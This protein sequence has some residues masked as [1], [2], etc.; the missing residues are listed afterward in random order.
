M[1]LIIV[2][3]ELKDLKKNGEGYPDPTACEAIVDAEGAGADDAERYHKLIG[4][5]LRIIEIAGFKPEE[6]IVLK[7]LRTGKIWR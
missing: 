6:R 5:V 7:D 3:N 4:C 1:M 2:K